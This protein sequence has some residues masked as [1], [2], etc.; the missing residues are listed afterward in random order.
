MSNIQKIES[1]DENYLKIEDS[2]LAISF[3]TYQ[4]IYH[5]ITGQNE[6]LEVLCKDD[7]LLDFS[8]VEQL[9]LTIKQVFN[10]HKVIGTSEN[11]TIF[12]HKEQKEV[13]SSFERFKI[14]NANSPSP[15]LAVIIKYNFSILLPELNNPQQYSITVRLESRL[16][17]MSRTRAIPD[18]FINYF[19]SVATSPAHIRIEYVDYVVARGFVEAFKH[20]VD[21]CKKSAKNPFISFIKKW[22]AFFTI[23]L[24]A[25]IPTVFF[26]MA[27]IN[28][29]SI[30]GDENKN[31][32]LAQF[33]LG[34]GSGM[35][36][37]IIL[38]GVL[39]SAILTPFAKYK[40]L[41]YINLN[42][43]DKNLI[44]EYA[45][46]QC[47]SFKYAGLKLVLTIAVGYVSSKLAMFL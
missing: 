25:L 33:L 20:W 15:T 46:A 31:Y 23:I 18:D 35:L 12:H 2:R 17:L 6:A 42:K 43:G 14:Y 1:D 27:Y 16:A 3:K 26:L 29:K 39:A 22:N 44:D 24:T 40:P 9:N 47:R 34:T 7:L 10:V 21:G 32:A 36:L 11:I 41:S 30:M 19:E 5:Q 38:G 4:D 37:L 13:F 8:D 45:S 28:A